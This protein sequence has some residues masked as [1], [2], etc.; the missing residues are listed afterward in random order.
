MA[1]PV[2]RPLDRDW[3]PIATALNA[4]AVPAGA[5][6]PPLDAVSF[7]DGFP[8]LIVSHESI[9]QLNARMAAAAEG[10]DGT[11][12]GWDAGSAMG[13]FRPNITIRGVG[14]P[15][16]PHAEDR[17]KRLAIVAGHSSV[18]GGAMWLQGVKRCSRCIVT[19]TDQTTGVQGG[20]AA[21]PLAMLRTYRQSGSGSEA[22]VF[23]GMVRSAPAARYPNDRLLPLPPPLPLTVFTCDRTWCWSRRAGGGA[24]RWGTRFTSPS[25]LTSGPSERRRLKR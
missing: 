1:E 23:M 5:P 13:R 6:A 19:T 9:E 8:L 18:D 4:P 17:M 2:A 22:G 15:L 14:A 24:S 3:V 16:P 7:A 12:R 11:A 10:G 21:Q 25:G 20:R